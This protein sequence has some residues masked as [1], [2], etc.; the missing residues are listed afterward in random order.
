MA[1]GARSSRPEGFF[2]LPVSVPAGQAGSGPR[3]AASKTPTPIKPQVPQLES[4][5]RSRPRA[6]P[7]EDESPSHRPES[8]SSG[9]KDGDFSKPAAHAACQRRRHCC[10]SRGALRTRPP[11]A[12]TGGGTNGKRRA[13]ARGQ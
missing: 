2:W 6:R 12:G 10:G 8:R 13:V 11:W 1:L 3:Q 5:G 4:A 7:P 9:V